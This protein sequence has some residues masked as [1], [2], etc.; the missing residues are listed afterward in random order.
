MLSKDPEERPSAAQV[1]EQLEAQLLLE[2]LQAMAALPLSGHSHASAAYRHAG[3]VLLWAAC[4]VLIG[5]ML[6]AGAWYGGMLALPG[7]TAHPPS[8]ISMGR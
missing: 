1:L 2:E 8:Q 3:R 5:L 6:A 4:L 7:K